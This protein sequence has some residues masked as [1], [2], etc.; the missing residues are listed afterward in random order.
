MFIN[1]AVKN[2]NKKQCYMHHGHCR[3]LHN[4]FTFGCLG[5]TVTAHADL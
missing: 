3:Y 4:L 1:A 2:T 5:T